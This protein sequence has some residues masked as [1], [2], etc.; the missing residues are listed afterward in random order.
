[1]ACVASET[2]PYYNHQAAAGKSPIIDTRGNCPQFAEAPPKPEASR[3]LPRL[4]K[5]LNGQMPIKKVR[6]RC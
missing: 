6:I 2:R 1:M 3:G 4:M 5:E